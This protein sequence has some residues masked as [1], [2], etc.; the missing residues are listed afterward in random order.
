MSY[1]ISP[2]PILCKKSISKPYSSSF[3][4]SFFTYFGTFLLTFN[5]ILGI[6]D[7][8]SYF[9]NCWVLLFDLFNALS[10]LLVPLS[11]LFTFSFMIFPLFFYS[12]SL[13]GDK[14]TFCAFILIGPAFIFKV[15]SLI[16]GFD[17]VKDGILVFPMPLTGVG[18]AEIL[19]LATNPICSFVILDDKAFYCFIN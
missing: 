11:G 17:S 15:L 16:I 5:F 1:I 3:S 13:F 18:K 6:P 14:S 10:G 2:R 12:S 19:S 9:C 7:D 8:D 4:G